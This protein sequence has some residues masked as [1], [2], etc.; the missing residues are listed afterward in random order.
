MS[1][2][3]Q[4]GRQNMKTPNSGK[5]TRGGR[6][7]GGREVGVTGSPALRGALDGMSTGYYDICWQIELQ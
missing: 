6:K 4:K 2:K 7:G 3:Y 5:P 1:G